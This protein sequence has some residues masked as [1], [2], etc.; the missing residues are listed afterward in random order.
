LDP[1]D[2]RRPQLYA[3]P[4][5]QAKV[6]RIRE[7][8]RHVADAHDGTITN[9]AISWELMYPALTGAIIGVRNENEAREMIG[10]ATW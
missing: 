6:Q 8:F 3:Q 1:K 5:N 7:A 2:F 9:A 10:G 4:K